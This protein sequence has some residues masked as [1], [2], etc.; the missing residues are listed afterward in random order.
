MQ[1]F[2]LHINYKMLK[3]LNK[4]FTKPQT[5]IFLIT[6]IK[7][8]FLAF[9]LRSLQK[10]TS[11]LYVNYLIFAKILPKQKGTLKGP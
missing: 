2:F 8:N 6:T 11:D 4:Y 10:K 9:Y 3:I 5:Y 7:F 1:V